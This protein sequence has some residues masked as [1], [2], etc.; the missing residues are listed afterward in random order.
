MHGI[1]FL[2]RLAASQLVPWTFMNLNAWR[3]STSKLKCLVDLVPV[4]TDGTNSS[5]FTGSFYEPFLLLHKTWTSDHHVFFRPGSDLDSA[6][7]SHVQS[8]S[9]L[10]IMDDH[11]SCHWKLKNQKLA[12]PVQH[13]YLKPASKSKAR[14]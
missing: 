5:S 4:W 7:R 9:T 3:T 11:L 10:K 8:C 6:L 14:I 2:L 1:A 13:I 12:L